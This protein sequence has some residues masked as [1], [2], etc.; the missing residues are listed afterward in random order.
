MRALLLR[1]A[2]LTLIFLAGLALASFVTT[3]PTQIG[4]LG[5]VVAVAAAVLFIV[6]LA[7]AGRRRARR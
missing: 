1:L 3:V 2:I 4:T 6:T 7:Q 5:V